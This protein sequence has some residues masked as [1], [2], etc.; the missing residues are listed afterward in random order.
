MEKTETF[1]RSR[2]DVLNFNAV[3]QW[4]M[5]GVL[6]AGSGLLWWGTLSSLIKTGGF[7]GIVSWQTMGIGL[8]LFQSYKLTQLLRGHLQLSQRRRIVAIRA[9]LNL[10][11]AANVVALGF[12]YLAN[13]LLG[14][15]YLT[16]Q[17]LDNFL[18]FIAVAGT[19][20]LLVDFKLPRLTRPAPLFCLI[21]VS[22]VIPQ[23]TLVLSSQ[24][25]LIP[26]AAIIGVLLIGLQR[27]AVVGMEYRAAKRKHGASSA[28][29]PLRW[30]LASDWLNVAA[31]LL[32]FVS[33]LSCVS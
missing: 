6:L 18:L 9:I 13:P 14:R 3:F 8:A 30:T 16:E 25:G 10:N 27:I 26:A 5:I 21:M 12:I 11:I 19:M 24:L 20:C 28:L 1:G 23:A 29:A 2:S 15:F 32:V 33:W 31:A 4:F 7:Q 22:R 17:D